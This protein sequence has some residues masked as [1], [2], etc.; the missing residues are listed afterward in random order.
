MTAFPIYKD[1][2]RGDPIAIQVELGTKLAAT[3]NLRRVHSEEKKIQ[4][5]I[6]DLL[7]LPRSVK[8]SSG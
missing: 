3:S 6:L 2:Y 5:L 1:F 8:A 7:S 4:G